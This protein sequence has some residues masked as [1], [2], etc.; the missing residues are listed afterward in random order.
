MNTTRNLSTL[1]HLLLLLL[2]GLLS[3][4]RAQRCG[5]VVNTGLRSTGIITS[6]GYPDHYPE[7]ATCSWLIK[8][9]HNEKIELKFW[10]FDVTGSASCS[11]DYVSIVA[12][13]TRDE[14]RFCGSQVPGVITSEQ[15]TLI[16]TFS[17]NAKGSCRGFNATYHVREESLSCGETTKAQEFTFVSPS[18]PEGV[19]NDS[20]ECSVTIDHGCESPIC[21]LRLDFDEFQLQPP[22]WGECKY[23]RFYAESATPLPFLCGANNGSHMYVN[24]EGRSKTQLTFLLRQ[25]E[26]Y[27]YNCYDIYGTGASNTKGDGEA[28]HHESIHHRMRERR[29]PT[30]L[31]NPQEAGVRLPRQATTSTTAQT[32]TNT[33]TT[34]PTTSTT[35]GPTTSTTTGPTTTST[36]TGP[37]TAPT[38]TE[39][40]VTVA[41]YNYK[42]A[43]IVNFP[44][45]RAWSIRVTQIPCH[46]PN[47][48]VPKAPVG[49]LQYYQG[50]T[51]EFK[52]F[53]FDGVSCYSEDRWCDFTT[54]QHVSDCDVR[55]GYT[56]H[57]N[58]LDY[59]ICVEPESGFCGIQYQQVGPD[60]FSLTNTTSYGGSHLT[61]PEVADAGCMSDYL[62]IPGAEN[63][64]DSDTYE[65]FCGTKLGTAR[66][67]GTVI[68]YSKPFTV[69][70]VTDADEFSLV[71]DYMNRGFHLSYSQ[72]PCKRSG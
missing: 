33:P 9:P 65:R 6:P 44:T 22:Y 31:P 62:W 28:L 55:V 25:L 43:E 13:N 69:R 66:K 49:C 56:G 53:N 29:S 15:D 12:S 4:A 2:L 10:D 19:G 37:T 71:T 67:W 72:I 41:L 57:L 18:Y 36:N 63:E 58:N 48:R 5:G 24:V 21:Q 26:Y 40:D 7:D 11:G 20:L 45:R 30:H 51:G 1:V 59:S 32:T 34:G 46:C 61:L 23:D 54:I 8:A 17:S 52:S 3:G 64:H 14:Q 39:G 50:L 16:L 70:M 42:D 60:G 47:S 35:T 38:T 27:L 68:S